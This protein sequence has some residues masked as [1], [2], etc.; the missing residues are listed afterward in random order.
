[1]K[2]VWREGSRGS[3]GREV[4]ADVF[5][6]VP[7]S[8]FLSFRAVEAGVRRISRKG[9]W[10]AQ[11]EGAKV[12]GTKNTVECC[13]GRSRQTVRGGSALEQAGEARVCEDR[14]LCRDFSML[15]PT[16]SYKEVD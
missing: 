16:N 4:C 2:S 6:T 1:M 3:S 8:P 10:D 12:G 15:R 7:F 13:G 11:T 5:E 14:D 9:G